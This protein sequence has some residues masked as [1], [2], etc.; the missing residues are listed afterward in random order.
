MVSVSQPLNPA[1]DERARRVVRA[2][3]RA[4]LDGVSAADWL[5]MPCPALE[6]RSP[7]SVAKESEDGCARVCA[8]L[9]AA[10]CEK[11]RQ[12]ITG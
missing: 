11:E 3:I 2:A 5:V 8:A 1:A 12:D 9:D 10:R 4:Y 7:L 6:G